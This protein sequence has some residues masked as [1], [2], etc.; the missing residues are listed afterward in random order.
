MR[1]YSAKETYNFKKP[2]DR[3]HPIHT[4]SL[5]ILLHNMPQHST[6]FI[7]NVSF[8]MCRC[9]CGKHPVMVWLFLCCKW[10]HLRFYCTTC[11]FTA[12][13]SYAPSL[14][15]NVCV[16]VCKTYS[17]SMICFVLQIH[18]QNTPQHNMQY[19]HAAQDILEGVAR[20]VALQHTVSHCNLLN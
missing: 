2:T 11:R 13:F 12:H 4:D 9:V 14:I 6:L 18:T 19:V 7:R 3:S 16:C 10:I 17:D 5:A 20:V 15:Q 8:S 1:L